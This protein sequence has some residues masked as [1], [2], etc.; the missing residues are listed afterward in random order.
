MILGGENGVG[1]MRM[2]TEEEGEEIGGGMMRMRIGEEIGVGKM[3]TEEEGE[4]I[5]V[6]MLRRMVG[7]GRR[8][9]VVLENRCRFSLP[10]GQGV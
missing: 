7:V 3:R 5:G 1:R 9:Q 8:Q 4:V 10:L 2:R 6:V